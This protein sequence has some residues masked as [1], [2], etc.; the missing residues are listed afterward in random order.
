MGVELV[1]EPGP[2]ELLTTG[3]DAAIW[4]RHA[5]YGRR[6]GL[7]TTLTR[8]VSADTGAP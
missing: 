8:R 5:A 7:R 4:W 6:G 2:A 1:G 3:A